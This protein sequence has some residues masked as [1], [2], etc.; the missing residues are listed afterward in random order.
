MNAHPIQARE[1]ATSSIDDESSFDAA[2]FDSAVE[3]CF[4]KLDKLVMRLHRYP[5]D[6]I[7][8]AMGVYLGEL[9]GALFDERQ[10]T[11]D[12]V[13]EFLCDIESGVLGAHG[14]AER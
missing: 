4:E 14:P 9:L 6:A 11:A 3:H 8:V 7:I 5:L 12:D 13:R 2:V 10:C 1:T